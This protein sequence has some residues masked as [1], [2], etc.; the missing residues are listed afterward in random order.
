MNNTKWKIE[1]RYYIFERDEEGRL[2]HPES[3]GL[4]IFNK[5]GY[6]SYNQA[7]KD[8]E[9][10]MLSCKNSNLIIQETFEITPDL[11]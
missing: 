7:F 1:K 9:L 5:Y 2:K 10:K 4:C 8:I 3:W 11:D 6:S